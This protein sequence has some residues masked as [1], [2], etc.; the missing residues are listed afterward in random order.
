MSGL[1]SKQSAAPR[2]QNRPIANPV[3]PHVDRHILH[4]H[5]FRGHAGLRPLHLRAS[6]IRSHE[7]VVRDDA[8]NI[9]RAV[10]RNLVGP[11]ATAITAG[12]HGPTRV[13]LTESTSMGAVLA[14]HKAELRTV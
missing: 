7:P 9:S 11:L 4:R 2:F 14:G 8:L 6:R 10:F 13:A 12:Q 5:R 1:A 3:A